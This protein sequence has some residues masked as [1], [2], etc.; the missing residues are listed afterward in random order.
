MFLKKVSS[1]REVKLPMMESR[2]LMF[3]FGFNLSIPLFNNNKSNDRT[4]DA[5]RVSRDPSRTEVCFSYLVGRE[6]DDTMGKKGDE[7]K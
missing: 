4:A 3:G 2:T 6:G 5:T 7:G 1:G